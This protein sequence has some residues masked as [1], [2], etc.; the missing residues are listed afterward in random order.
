MTDR[1]IYLGSFSDQPAPR[2]RVW[3]SPRRAGGTKPLSSV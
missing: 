1:A 2:A 3:R